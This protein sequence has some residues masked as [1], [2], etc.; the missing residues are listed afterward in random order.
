[1]QLWPDSTMCALLKALMRLINAT[2]WL[3]F[4]DIC[5]RHVTTQT[6]KC[7][8]TALKSTNIIGIFL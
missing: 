6:I 8:R 2:A 1:M 3:I 4:M 5:F 7:F